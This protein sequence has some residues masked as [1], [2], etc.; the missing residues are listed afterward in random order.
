MFWVLK[1]FFVLFFC[2]FFSCCD[3]VILTEDGLINDGG[4]VDL[5]RAVRCGFGQGFAQQLSGF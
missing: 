5:V 4:N 1:F 2:F 3:V